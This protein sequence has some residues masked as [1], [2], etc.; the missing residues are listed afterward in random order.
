MR[1]QKNAIVLTL[2]LC[3]VVCR[4][5]P[6]TGVALAKAHREIRHAYVFAYRT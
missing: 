1:V 6:H 2:G 3:A 5:L 4:W